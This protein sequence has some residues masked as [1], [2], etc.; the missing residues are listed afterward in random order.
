MHLNNRPSSSHNETATII[1]EESRNQKGIRDSG[2][3]PSTGKT[4]R[5][6]RLPHTIV[7]QVKEE[8]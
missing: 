2:L 8:E 3:D 6:V 1:R 7:T 4:S 5:K